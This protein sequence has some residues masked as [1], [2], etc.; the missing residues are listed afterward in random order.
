M[1]HAGRADPALMKQMN[2]RNL[3]TVF[4]ECVAL[5]A[6]QLSARSGLSVVTV[7]AL[8][9]E[10]VGTGEVQEDRQAS[11]SAG[12]PTTIY[13]LQ[14]NFRCAAVV[15]GYQ[16]RGRDN[17]SLTVV[18][19]I[20]MTI[21]R[22]EQAM[23]EVTVESF[24]RML[25][26]AF[27]HFPNI[28]VVGFGLPGAEFNGHIPINDYPALIGDAFVERLKQ[29]Y[30]VPVIVA[31]DIN[32]AIYGRALDTVRSHGEETIVGIFKPNGYAP[33]AG[34]MIGGAIHTGRRNLAGEVSF[35][36]LGIDWT[37]LD[38][39]NADALCE[40]LSRLVAVMAAVLSPDLFMLYGDLP[41][42]DLAGRVERRASELLFGRFD[43][44]VQVS[45]EIEEDFEHGM[46][47]LTMDR[48]WA[49]DCGG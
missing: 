37:G 43:I 17:V 2:L 8:L 11:V 48:L 6:A 20:G 35:M 15:C 14:E 31:N 5:T 28:G 33:G 12:R 42:P 30:G 49:I 32:A 19:R 44:R 41:H 34:L 4:R 45:G 9:R 3:R 13:R 40:A 47:R 23:A 16:K 24:D 36:P 10:L 22:E 38:H 29:R 27:R 1:K 46:L 7:N 39:S 25:D 21:H 26:A 18:N